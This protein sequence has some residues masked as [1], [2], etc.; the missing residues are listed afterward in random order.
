M[1]SF[2]Q[3]NSYIDQG[4]QKLKKKAYNREKREEMLIE[5]N[6]VKNNHS[7]SY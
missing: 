5:H 2:E 6:K 4:I 7:A 1:N 3:K